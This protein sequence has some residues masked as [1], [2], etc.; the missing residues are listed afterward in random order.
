MLGG[1]TLVKT[2]II[3]I[4]KTADQLPANESPHRPA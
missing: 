2:P 4:G 3:C 1:K